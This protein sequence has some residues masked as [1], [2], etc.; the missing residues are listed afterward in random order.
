MNAASTIAAVCLLAATS[1]CGFGEEPDPPF[2]SSLGKSIALGDLSP[3]DI[4]T[5]C[6]DY[7]RYISSSVGLDELC[8]YAGVLMVKTQ[9]GDTAACRERKQECLDAPWQPGCRLTAASAADCSA[10][11]REAEACIGD[12]AAELIRL[13]KSVNCVDLSVSLDYPRPAS[14]ADLESKCPGF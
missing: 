14:C 12:E 1:A 11:V 5:F 10:T 13:M 8:T 7:Q 2:S 4:A 6:G 3:D 9:G